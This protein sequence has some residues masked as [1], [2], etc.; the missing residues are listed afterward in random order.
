MW[1]H[2]IVFKLQFLFSFVVLLINNS[3][4]NINL[5]AEHIANIMYRE[6]F[7]VRFAADAFIFLK[8]RLWIFEGLIAN[9]TSF[10]WFVRSPAGDFHI[11]INLNRTDNVSFT[12]YLWLLRVQILFPANFGLNFSLII[13]MLFYFF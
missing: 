12:E 1:I 8:I 10:L 13:E 7:N 6:F 11:L 5:I 3:I 4:S 2:A 9:L